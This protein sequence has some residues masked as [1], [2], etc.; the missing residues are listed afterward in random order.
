MAVVLY[1]ATADNPIL[2]PSDLHILYAPSVSP[3]LALFVTGPPGSGKTTLVMKAAEEL[4]RRGLRVGGMVSREIRRGG[5]R[6]GFEIV[7]LGTGRTGI[8]ASVDQPSGPSVGKYRVN[9]SDLESVGVESICRAIEACDV[10]VIDEVGPMEL[11]SE[12]F[13]QA[14]REALRSRKLVLGTIHFKARGGLID[15]IKRSRS[16]V[17]VTVTS[18]NREEASRRLVEEALRLAGQR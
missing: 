15:E 9:L 1:L 3:M 18:S 2:V 4:R 10:V 17:L 8:L 6:W 5:V 7:D 12:R 14:V 16:V 11:F 13:K